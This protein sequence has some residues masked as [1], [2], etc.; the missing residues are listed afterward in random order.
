MAWAGGVFTRVRNW[1]QDKLNAINPQAA[2]FDQEDDNFATGLNNCVTKDGLNQPSATM[3]WNGQRLTDLGDATGA[4]D[5]VNRQFGDARYLRATT[6]S[7]TATITGCTVNPTG[8]VNYERVGNRVMLWT[9]ASIQA[10]SNT[11]SMTMTGIPADIQ[12]A[13]NR[14]VMMNQ[15]VDGTL[16]AYGSANINGATITFSVAATSFTPDRINFSETLFSTAGGT[17]GIPSNWIAFYSAV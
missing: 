11:I 16:G 9:T 2:L 5:A 10:V 1:A 14:G 7:F 6:G 4:T 15:L 12:S 8:T 3:D 13:G 17:K